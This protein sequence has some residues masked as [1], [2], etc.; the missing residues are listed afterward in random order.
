MTFRAFCY[1]FNRIRDRW[2]LLAIVLLCL[3][4]H[5]SR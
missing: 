4:L 3:A 1:R 5:L 2:Y